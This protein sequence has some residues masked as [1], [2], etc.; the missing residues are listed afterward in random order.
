MPACRPVK[1]QAGRRIAMRF[2]FSL[3]VRLLL[4][5]LLAIIPALGSIL[6]LASEQRNRAA[7]DVE[8]E[9]LRLTRLAASNHD[10]LI[11]GAR[12]LLVA[13]AQ[14]PEVRQGE[15]AACNAL[16]G[17]LLKEYRFYTGF[18]AVKPNGCVFCGAPFLSQPINLLDRAWYQRLMQTRGFVTS[19]YLMGRIS[20]KAAI[21]AAY[22]VLDAAGQIQAVVAAGLDLALFNQ[23]AAQAQLPQGAAL[24]VIDHTGVILARY[25]EPEKWV[26][27]SLPE[28]PLIE[29]ILGQGEGTVQLPGVDGVERLYAFTPLGSTQEID[30]YVSIG[31]SREAAFADV[32]RALAASL[33][34]LAGVAVLALGAVWFGGDAFILRRVN[35]LLT[36]TR[37]LA[38]GDLSTRTG[39]AYGQGDR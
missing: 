12:Q 14:L 5:V 21:V 37:R 35:A 28:T 20:G 22:P 27:E 10:R 6:Y 8:A 16:F 30:A 25:P 4:L 39:L 33:M 18:T 19:G 29:T 26:G 13:L 2:L 34:G 24:T 7:A 36:A 31:I 11:E 23:L 32:D 15:P 1:A 38:A 17:E 3:R 9:A